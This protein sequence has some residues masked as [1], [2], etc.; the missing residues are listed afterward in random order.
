MNQLNLKN[1]I[2]EQT[3]N[4]SDTFVGIKCENGKLKIYLPLGFK[5]DEDDSVLR[6]DLLM[7]FNAIKYTSENKS[8]DNISPQTIQ[9]E[10]NNQFFPISSFLYVISDFLKR[11]YYKEKEVIFSRG[12]FYKLNLN[13]LVTD[14][15]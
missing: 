10:D 12:E 5:V 15:S 6:K 14:R 1:F 11:G 13:N 4:S 3:E 8:S 2:S 7:L 9:H